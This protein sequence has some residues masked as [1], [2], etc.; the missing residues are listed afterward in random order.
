MATESRYSKP[1][2]S[3]NTCSQMR[4]TVLLLPSGS[5]T[6]GETR[7]SACIC[8]C[9]RVCNQTSMYA[10]SAER[11]IQNV[12]AL[13]FMKGGNRWVY[14]GARVQVYIWCLFRPGACMSWLVMEKYQLPI[15]SQFTF[16]TKILANARLISAIGRED[17]S[18]A[19]VSLGN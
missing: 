1:L 13:S 8:R 15:K 5:T 6:K 16:Q 14:D 17:V 19:P 3:S 11:L 7:E 12:H 10:P 4:S 18:Q 9:A 2:R